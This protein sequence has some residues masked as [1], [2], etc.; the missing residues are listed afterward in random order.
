MDTYFECT[1][2][3]NKVVI[4]DQKAR[5]VKKREIYA[6][7]L[8]TVGLNE[9]SY[10]VDSR[11]N[12][13]EAVPNKNRFKTLCR[14]TC[15]MKDDEILI[16][17]NTDLYSNSIGY[18]VRQ[19]IKNDTNAY[20]Y[21]ICSAEAAQSNIN[22]VKS[23]LKIAFYTD[24]IKD[25]STFGLQIFDKNKKII[26]NSC[27][28][29]MSIRS[30]VFKTNMNGTRSSN[31]YFNNPITRN[32]IIPSEDLCSFEPGDYCAIQCVPGA[33]YEHEQYY[34][35]AEFLM[36]GYIVFTGYS[37]GINYFIGRVLVMNTNNTFGVDLENINGD[38]S[39]RPFYPTLCDIVSLFVLR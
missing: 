1:N 29:I 20:I 23:H 34:G 18:I 21:I 24:V 6:T 7:K 11:P 22:V 12:F 9:Y 39:N 35:G 33:L 19:K 17:I 10:G 2:S 27:H 38:I 25:D 31:C 36:T 14:L 5:Y 13:L 26:F 30:F 3:S 37:I 32:Y 28:D 16:A 15:P 4:D 8:A